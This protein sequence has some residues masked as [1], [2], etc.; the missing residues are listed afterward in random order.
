M[1]RRSRPVEGVGRHAP[2]LPALLR[3][4]VVAVGSQNPLRPHPQV[5]RELL[6]IERYQ[7]H[8]SV[9]FLLLHSLGGRHPNLGASS[10]QL[11]DQ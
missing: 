6:A 2:P 5:R 11:H 3:T 9:V 10:L 8:E 1:A 7:N 4:R